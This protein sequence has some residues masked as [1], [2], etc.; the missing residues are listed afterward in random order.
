[1]GHRRTWAHG[2]QQGKLAGKFKCAPCRR[3]DH[4]LHRGAMLTPAPLPSSLPPSPHHP[5]A[6]P[7]PHHWRSSSGMIGRS[8]GST[9]VTPDQFGGVAQGLQRARVTWLHFH[10]TPKRSVLCQQLPRVGWHD[11]RVTTGGSKSERRS[12]TEKR[13]ARY[14]ASRGESTVRVES[15]RSLARGY[16]PDGAGVRWWLTEGRC[17]MPKDWGM[18]GGCCD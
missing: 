3:C 9:S 12:A 1:M 4:Q 15:D 2:A 14:S 6:V 18:G 11:R 5:R 8:S 7:R 17:D 16:W 10:Q 13:N